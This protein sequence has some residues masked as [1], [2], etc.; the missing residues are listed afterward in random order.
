MEIVITITSTFFLA[1]CCEVAIVW[2]RCHT[3]ERCGK[4]GIRY[5][6]I[7]A[8]LFLTVCLKPFSHPLNLFRGRL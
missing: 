8:D 6:V 1:W 3:R 4:V 7:C 2:T 5:W